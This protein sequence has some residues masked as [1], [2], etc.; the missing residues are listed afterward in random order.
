M[1]DAIDAHTVVVDRHGCIIAVNQAWRSFVARNGGCFPDVLEGSQY[2]SVCETATGSP[3][4]DEIKPLLQDVLSSKKSDCALT[5]QCRTPV[6]NKHFRAAIRGFSHSDN[7]FAII[8]HHDVTE[9]RHIADKASASEAQLRRIIDSSPDC[10]M[11]M[12]RACRV[13]SINKAGLAMFNADSLEQL[14]IERVI[15]GE[16][17]KALTDDVAAVS[18][19]SDA[20]PRQFEIVGVQGA[21]NI[22]YRCVKLPSSDDRNLEVLVIA[23]DITWQKTAEDLRVTTERREAL[24]Q[25]A[26]GIAHEFN[27]MLLAAATYLDAAGENVDDSSDKERDPLVVKASMLVQQA[28][29]LSASLLELFVGPETT[30]LATLDLQEWLSECVNRIVSTL[31]TT[32]TI[33]TPTLSTPHSVQADAIALEQVLRILISNA[34]DATDHHGHV[35]VHATN[36]QQDGVDWIEIYVRDNGPGVAAQ[37]QHRIFEPFFTTRSRSR[38]SGLGLA[39]ASKL[40]EHQGGALWYEPNKHVGSTF[41]IRLRAVGAGLGTGSGS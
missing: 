33:E 26:G 1:F 7:R 22:E 35:I 39:I 5:Y 24:A 8:T 23:R 34:S 32:L 13:L 14:K 25:L 4:V 27:S 3:D 16:S 20:Q 11:K 10:I 17:Y 31:P 40:V 38:R 19:G 21:R 6:G 28:Q 37:D 41:I 9:L 29:S 15:A 2:L 12:D 30:Q 18:R 36:T